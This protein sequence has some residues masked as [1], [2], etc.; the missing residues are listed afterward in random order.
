MPPRASRVPTTDPTVVPTRWLTEDL[1][2]DAGRRAVR[3]WE[4]FNQQERDAVTGLMALPGANLTTAL[5]APQQGVRRARSPSAT[6]PAGDGAES[7]EAPPRQRRRTAYHQPGFYGR[8]ARVSQPDSE[9]EVRRRLY[10]FQRSA[11]ERQFNDENS[12]YDQGGDDE[13]GG[14]R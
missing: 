11:N 14:E 9:G 5:S 10:L 12:G 8:N 13:L 1:L 4:G 2:T 7:D 6:D 3:T